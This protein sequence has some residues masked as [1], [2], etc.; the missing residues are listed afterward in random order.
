MTGE[1][2][3]RRLIDTSVL[4]YAYDVSDLKKHEAASVLLA[5][6]QG[7]G[8]CAISVQN[9][10][11]FCR[12][13]TE[14]LPSPLLHAQV[15]SYVLE[16]SGLFTLLVYTDKTVLE[17]LS[18]SAAYG[19]HFFDALLAA[20]MKEHYI[21]EVITED[22]KDFAKVPGIKAVNPFRK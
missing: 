18:I 3:A 20:T 7:D 1:G 21:S 11:E 5:S 22:E 12:V 17:A 10:A 19:V 16:L 15:R 2:D 9:L 14:K 4:V 13:M 8:D 6:L